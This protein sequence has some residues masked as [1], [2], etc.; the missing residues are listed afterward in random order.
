MIL[1]VLGDLE[2]RMVT[3]L[4]CAGPTVMRGSLNKLTDN[5]DRLTKE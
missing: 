1:R 3:G 2:S 4:I 5:R